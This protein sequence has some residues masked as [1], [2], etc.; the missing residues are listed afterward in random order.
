MMPFSIDSHYYSHLQS[1]FQLKLLCFP[2]RLAFQV[3]A[4]TSAK[5]VFHL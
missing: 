3:F 1:D 2:F 5:R 4:E